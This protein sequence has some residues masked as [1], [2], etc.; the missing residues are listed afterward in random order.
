MPLSRFPVGQPV[1]GIHLAADERQSLLEHYRLSH[2]P[3]IRF[4]AHILLLLD[5][6]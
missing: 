1:S 3:A 5:D 6:G 2:D 4:R